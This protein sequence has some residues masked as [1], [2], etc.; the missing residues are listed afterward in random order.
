MNTPSLTFS[1]RPR[2]DGKFQ[3]I[4]TF[5][6]AANAFGGYYPAKVYRKLYTLDKLV[7]Q[8]ARYGTTEQRNWAAQI[9]KA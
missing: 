2:R 3:A 8:I 9:T 1:P 5:P 4:L 7:E 6:G